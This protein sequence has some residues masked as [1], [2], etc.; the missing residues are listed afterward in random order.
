LSGRVVT[1]N[2]KSLESPNELEAFIISPSR[3]PYDHWE[4]ASIPV[5]LSNNISITP[6][7][8]N[9]RDLLLRSIV[10]LHVVIILRILL[11]KA[12][13]GCMEA[14]IKR[15][16]GVDEGRS[17]VVRHSNRRQQR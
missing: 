12:R 16:V 15:G 5:L 13:R 4:L 8:C 2:P 3:P 1:E 17:S 11:K 9:C 10:K 7:A 6:E 14:D